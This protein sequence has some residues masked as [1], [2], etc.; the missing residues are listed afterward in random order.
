ML[1]IIETLKGCGVYITN[2]LPTGRLFMY[3]VGILLGIFAVVMIILIL[4]A[5][6]AVYICLGYAVKCVI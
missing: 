6:F 5:V 3:L 2:S 1:T 4:T